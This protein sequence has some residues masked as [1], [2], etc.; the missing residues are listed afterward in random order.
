M[1]SNILETTITSDCKSDISIESKR[2]SSLVS[3]SSSFTDDMEILNNKDITPLSSSG[4]NHQLLQE[5]NEPP[6]VNKKNNIPTK[7][8][9][10]SPTSQLQPRHEKQISA[11][12]LKLIKDANRYDPN[13][14]YSLPTGFL[15]PRKPKKLG[16]YDE[17][18]KEEQELKNQKIFKKKQEKKESIQ[19]SKEKRKQSM[20]KTKEKKRKER[21]QR[22]S[23]NMITKKS[24]LSRDIIIEGNGEI[25][26]HKMVESTNQEVDDRKLLKEILYY[27]ED[28]NKSQNNDIQQETKINKKEN[29]TE[30]GEGRTYYFIYID[31]KT[32]KKYSNFFIKDLPKDSPS[33]LIQS[34]QISQLNA[35]T[36]VEFHPSVIYPN[37]KETFE[38]DFTNPKKLVVYNPM[39]EIGR[40]IEYNSLIYL[41][42]LYT[43]YVDQEILPNLFEAYKNENVESFQNAVLKYNN[44][45]LKIPKDA[46]TK[47]LSNLEALPVSFIHFILTSVYV[48]TVLPDAKKLKKY[49]AFSNFVYGELLPSFLTTCY[50]Q[51]DLNDEKIFVDLGSGVGNC[52]IQ[53]ALEY[54]CKLSF[55]CE[56]MENA[57]DLTESQTRELEKRCKLLGINLGKTL[58]ELRTSFVDN[59]KVIEI[60]KKCD[61]LLINNF[62]F[63]AKMNGYIENLI[64]NVKVGC[65]IITLKTLRPYGF[66]ADSNNIDNILCRLKVDKFSLPEDSVSWTYTGG[67]EYYISTVTDFIDESLLTVHARVRNIR[68]P[69]YSYE[70]FPLQEDENEHSIGGKKSRGKKNKVSKTKKLKNDKPKKQKLNK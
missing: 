4:N 16:I 12:L 58:F 39:L 11:T 59:E 30:K 53:A 47:H 24:S 26:E 43:D 8:V 45:I 62:I 1:T 52:V 23:K 42:A 61:V 14:E 68:K 27:P 38:I 35:S 64:Q 60:L 21:K 51:C 13:C 54:G 9:E 18:L 34:N 22:T 10:V 41:P 49:V 44:Y 69:N 70:L 63:D 17:V 2:K 5:K 37:Y 6:K 28:K 50:Q 29:G 31:N 19:R 67:G 57:S 3:P 7:E 46:I 56:I 33:D 55:G 36:T 15:R 32:I 66:I 48:R 65:K 25:F 40:T 20:E